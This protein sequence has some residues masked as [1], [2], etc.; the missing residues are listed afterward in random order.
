MGQLD[1]RLRVRRVRS[2]DETESPCRLKKVSF[3]SNHHIL[4]E[5]CEKTPLYDKLC[6]N[7]GMR[8]KGYSQ[9]ELSDTQPWQHWAKRRW[10][11]DLSMPSFVIPEAG[12]IQTSKPQLCTSRVLPLHKWC[13]MS[14]L[15]RLWGRWSLYVVSP[16]SRP[17]VHSELE[18]AFIPKITSPSS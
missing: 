4:V 14:C 9:V 18:S 6:R 2:K 5:W 3:H 1:S 12:T 8:M 15:L 13:L 16:P 11:I 10:G 17:T 7:C